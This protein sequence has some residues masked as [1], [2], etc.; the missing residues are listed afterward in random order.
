MTC[1]LKQLAEQL[2]L[3]IGTVSLALRNSPLVAEKTRKR[4]TELAESRDYVQSSFGRALQSR[5]SKLIGVLIPTLTSSFF[6]ELLQGAGEASIAAGYGLMLGWVTEDREYAAPQINL[7]L[8]KEVDALIVASNGSCFGTYAQRFLRR[9][10]PVVFCNAVP[11]ENCSSVRTD[12]VLG[13]RLA[14][15]AMVRY[16]HKK[17]LC[18]QRFQPR[19]EGNTLAAQQYNVE[20]SGFET[21]QDALEKF[22]RDLGI[23][24]IVAHSDEEAS[25]ILQLLRE[26]GYSEKRDFSIIGYNDMSIASHPGFQLTTIAQHRK[27]LG[28]SSVEIAINM[29]NDPESGNVHKL[30][31][32]F[33]VERNTLRPPCRRTR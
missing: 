20:L 25:L 2:N 12:D 27:A 21:Y 23:T 7:M 15:E 28:A 11:A 9:S 32:P 26:M 1:T 16:G 19:W 24:G 17:L 10:K 18:C 5:C 31:N 4:V 3:S 29:L 6:N 33:L 13:G 22:R 14:V 8:E 30:L